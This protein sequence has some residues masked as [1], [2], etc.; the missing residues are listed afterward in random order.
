MGMTQF[1]SEERKLG[2]A[3]C[4]QRCPFIRLCWSLVTLV[5]SLTSPQVTDLE[6]ASYCSGFATH[7]L[8][9]KLSFLLG[10]LFTLWVELRTNWA[11]Q[12]ERMNSLCK[13]ANC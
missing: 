1:G 4:L 2:S 6:T 8:V 3:G 10:I 5:M 12:P 9:S 11:C 7:A 13:S